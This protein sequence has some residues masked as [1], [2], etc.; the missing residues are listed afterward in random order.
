[1]RKFTLLLAIA[2][3]SFACPHIAQA[4]SDGKPAK[5][6]EGYLYKKLQAYGTRS[7]GPCY[8]LQTLEGKKEVNYIVE[9]GARNPWEPDDVLERH[10]HKKVVVNGKYQGN[11]LYIDNIRLKDSPD[12][13]P[14]D[15]KPIRSIPLPVDVKDKDSSCDRGDPNQ[16]RAAWSQ[17]SA[18]VTTRFKT[19]HPCYELETIHATQAGEIVTVDIRYV[20]RPGVCAQCE[21]QQLLRYIIGGLKPVSDYEIRVRITV[22]GQTFQQGSLLQLTL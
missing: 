22:D 3:L 7:E 17:G 21:G 19:P 12:F 15:S 8:M 11:R 5:D 16:S 1:M 4:R 13:K 9:R 18:E 14:P 2:V 20:R 10:I 6:V